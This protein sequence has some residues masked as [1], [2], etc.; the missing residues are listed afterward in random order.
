[1]IQDHPQRSYT[2]PLSRWTNKKQS[3]KQAN[4]FSL[5][6]PGSKFF[7]IGRMGETGQR[8]KEIRF[9]KSSFYNVTLEPSHDPWSDFQNF[10]QTFTRI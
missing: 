8:W 3:Q 9:E 5:V 4:T 6:S 7:K 2:R 10:D 1:M